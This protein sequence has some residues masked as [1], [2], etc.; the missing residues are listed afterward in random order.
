MESGGW[1]C[2]YDAALSLPTSEADYSDWMRRAETQNETRYSHFREV[3]A[4]SEDLRF[5][6]LRC[7][8]LNVMMDEWKG[9]PYAVA[10]AQPW[11]RFRHILRHLEDLDPDVVCLNEVTTSFIAFVPAFPLLCENYVF[12]ARTMHPESMGNFVLVRKSLTPVFAAHALPACPRPAITAAVG[13]LTIAATHLSALS[14]N[15]ER[16]KM[17]LDHLVKGLKER[18][19]V[20]IVGDLNWHLDTEIESC[21]E[22][23]RTFS[24]SPVTFDALSNS[25]HQMLWPLG[26]EE[27]QMRLDRILW[28]NCECRKLKRIFDEPVFPEQYRVPDLNAGVVTRTFRTAGFWIPD[29]K[30]YLFPSDHF[31]LHFNI[32]FI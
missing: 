26:Y 18:Q 7:V 9:R 14:R 12:S 1:E 4:S 27:R 13:Q 5:E 6:E 22:E 3:S 16:R 20:V 30:E 28:R 31:G 11:M 23:F 8:S 10:V 15:V 2:R 17:Q 21:P 25:M 32:L 29:A 24:D 19:S